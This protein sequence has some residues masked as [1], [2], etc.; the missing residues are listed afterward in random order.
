MSKAKKVSI[1]LLGVFLIGCIVATV[2]A[3]RV[4]R[5]YTVARDFRAQVRYLIETG[6][7]IGE[8]PANET[9]ST[10]YLEA[11]FGDNPELLSK[12]KAVVS[13]GLADEPA[14]NLGEV[15]AMIVTY[16]KTDDGK[17]EDVVAHAIGGFPLGKMKPGFHRDG[18][19]AQQLDRNLWTMGN[20]VISFL[21]RDMVLFSE[22]TVA[23]SQQELIESL[24]SG[25]IMLLVESLRRP[26]YATAV[27]P[28]P[29]RIVP[30]Q[31]RGHIQAIVIKS[32]LG[33]QKG[34]IETTLLTPSSRSC[35][36]AYGI[37]KDMKT[38]ADMSLKTRWGGQVIETAWGSMVGSWWAYEMVQTLDKT[39]LASDQV[40]VRMKSDF[41]RVMVNVVLKSIERMSRDLAQMK[42]SLEEKM[43]PRIVDARLKS[44][45]PL[46][47]W[48][49]P[50]QWGPNWPIPPPETNVQE[51][52]SLTTTEQ[53][54]QA[55]SPGP[56]VA[57]PVKT[58]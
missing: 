4:Y 51:N 53:T 14:L 18:Y 25:D 27:F 30:S 43:D 5:V 49:N 36:Y 35:Q 17:V 45:K 31:L 3:F 1:F 41:G 58:P 13:K 32:S 22:E 37:L 15:A 42:G 2:A 56:V 50:H 29:K 12:L 21:G 54:A 11:I 7:T 33:Y 55:T 28:D 44:T 10:D 34:F 24:F 6:G 8:A 20:S 46:H 38:M 19:F 48:S 9:F 39:T 23:K 57:D 47:Y 40:L 26:M 16:H 52:V